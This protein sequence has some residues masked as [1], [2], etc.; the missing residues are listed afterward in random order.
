MRICSALQIAKIDTD[1]MYMFHGWRKLA[2]SRKNK[3]EKYVF[4]NVFEIKGL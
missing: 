3:A 1:I 2:K 4:V